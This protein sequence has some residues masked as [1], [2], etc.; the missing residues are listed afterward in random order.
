MAAK[1]VENKKAKKREKQYPNQ[2]NYEVAK[3]MQPQQK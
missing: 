3:E 2:D 1:K